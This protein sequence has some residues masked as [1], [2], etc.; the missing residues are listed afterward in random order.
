MMT[1]RQLL[2]NMDSAP[3]A[4]G[5][6][7]GPVLEEYREGDMTLRAY[8]AGMIYAQIGGHFT[9][10]SAR[11]EPGWNYRDPEGELL[12]GRLEFL[13]L[14]WTLWAFL[15]ASFRMDRI[16]IQ[17]ILS[18]ETSLQALK[19]DATRDDTEAARKIQVRETEE[20]L[21]QREHE[22]ELKRRILDTVQARQRDY[23]TA[24]F[25]EGASRKEMAERLGC[26]PE[27][28]R[29]RDYRIRQQLRKKWPK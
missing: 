6:G 24:R 10:F 9:A 3:T 2:G 17:K 19:A 18:T 28:L 26:S 13:D 14:D 25:F 8:R 15:V 27:A 23:V 1:L 7:F 12:V 16:Q 20:E 22:E 21:L 4:G 11:V 29:A 5:E